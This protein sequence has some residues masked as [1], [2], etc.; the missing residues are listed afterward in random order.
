MSRRAKSD[1][2]A[3]VYGGIPRAHLMPP[4]VAMRRRESARRRSL[5]AL[6]GLVAA[7]VIAGVVASFLYAAA[8]EQR[9]AEERRITDQLLATQLQYSEVT[10]VRGDL[11]TIADLRTELAAVEVLWAD[12]LAPYLSVLG[13]RNVVSEITVRSDE[14]AQPQLGVAGPLR[15]PRVATVSLIV[16]TPDVPRPWAWIRAWEQLDA[17]ADASIDRVTLNE[18]ESYD[19]AITI[20]LSID[21][22]SQR[23]APEGTEGEGS[24]DGDESSDGSE[25]SSEEGDQ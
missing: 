25:G 6:S 22:L 15:Q 7:V 21:A 5:I 14:P 17:F 18:G 16:T 2:G 11:Q 3:L 12:A 8:A 23:F 24:T 20:N 13:S 1:A 19:V 4:E 10:Q 9:L